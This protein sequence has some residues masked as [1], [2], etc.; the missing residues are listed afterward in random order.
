MVD[1]GSFR[2]RSRRD[3]DAIADGAHDGSPLSELVSQMRSLGDGDGVKPSHALTEFVSA[4]TQEHDVVVAAVTAESKARTPMI[5]QLSALAATTV[6]K[7][8]LTL[9][10]I[11]I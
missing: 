2:R 4:Q 1:S 8:V 10:L 3:L 9:S 5:A 6:G 7:V 11:H